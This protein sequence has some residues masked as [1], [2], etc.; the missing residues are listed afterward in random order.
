MGLCCVMATY[1]KYDLLGWFY[2][3][4]YNTHTLKGHGKKS[5]LQLELVLLLGVRLM[6]TTVSL[7]A[8]RL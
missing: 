6:L 8:M 4:L 7:S 2:A 1:E 3:R 5:P